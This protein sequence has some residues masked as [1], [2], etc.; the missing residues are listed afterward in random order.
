MTKKDYQ[1]IADALK[2]ARSYYGEGDGAYLAGITTASLTLA[3]AL[4]DTNPRFDSDRFLEACGVPE[5]E[6]NQ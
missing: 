1:L 6:R 5:G 4:R 3:T 2:L